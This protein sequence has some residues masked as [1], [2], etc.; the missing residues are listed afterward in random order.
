M[1]RSDF[2]APAVCVSLYVTSACG[3]G[4]VLLLRFS[5]ISTAHFQK[6]LRARLHT[7]SVLPKV[8]TGADGFCRG[9]RGSRLKR[10]AAGLA[11]R[12]SRELCVVC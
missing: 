1:H 11:C 7:N 10:Q 6:Y 8:L 3:V 4:H 9:L 2:S 5:L 12:G